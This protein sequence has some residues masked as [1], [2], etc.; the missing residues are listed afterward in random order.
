MTYSEI[1]TKQY[2]CQLLHGTISYLMQEV[3]CYEPKTAERSDSTHP[4]PT[5]DFA[6]PELR[7]RSGADQCV[8]LNGWARRHYARSNERNAA[9]YGAIFYRLLFR[10][11]PL[12]EEF[13]D[14]LVRQVFRGARARAGE[15]TTRSKPRRAKPA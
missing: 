3:F 10:S 15:A 1:G 9:R 13:S 7:V 6:V 8:L 11:A 2:R 5:F 12:T 14:K 4:L